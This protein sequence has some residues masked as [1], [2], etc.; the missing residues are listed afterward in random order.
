M[1]FR[2]THS[3]QA[4]LKVERSRPGFAATMNRYQITLLSEPVGHWEFAKRETS[5][6]MGF[7]PT[8]FV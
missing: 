2:A 4:D 8:T 7:E 6:T 1:L 5:K 3:M